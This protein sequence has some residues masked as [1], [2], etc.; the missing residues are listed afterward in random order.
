MRSGIYYSIA[1][2]N[3]Y[4]CYSA[5]KNFMII[6]NLSIVCNLPAADI[7]FKIISIF[8]TNAIIW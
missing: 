3:G 1:K 8:Y 4:F 7:I 2:Y 5:S 6:P